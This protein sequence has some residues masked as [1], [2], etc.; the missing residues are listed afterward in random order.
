MDSGHDERLRKRTA[1][2]LTL[3]GEIFCSQQLDI[4]LKPASFF[5]SQES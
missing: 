1:W 2:I 4:L 3:D 5:L